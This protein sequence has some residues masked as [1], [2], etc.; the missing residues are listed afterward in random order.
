MAIIEESIL[1]KSPVEQVFAYVTDVANLTR[2]VADMV[3][4]EQTSQGPMGTGT[5]FKGA[6]KIVGQR[7]PWTS[8]VTQYEINKKWAAT[9][10]SDSTV[11]EEIISFDSADEG[12]KLTAKYDIRLGG[13]LKLV[14]PFMAN[15]MRS[16]TIKNLATLKK[17]LET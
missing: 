7:M 11:I 9:S 10:T 3:E 12:T 8:R 16:Q 13:F 5:T 4:A 14:S 15:S 2:W 1:I 6:N 17:L